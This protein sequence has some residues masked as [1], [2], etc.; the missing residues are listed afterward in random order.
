MSKH[1]TFYEISV[2]ARLL[3]D[4]G[5]QAAVQQR[6]EE[7]GVLAAQRLQALHHGL[8]VEHDLILTQPLHG[9]FTRSPTQER[10]LLGASSFSQSS[11]PADGSE[12]PVDR[13]LRG[14]DVAAANVSIKVTD[15]M[16]SS[17]QQQIN[18]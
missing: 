13:G 12:E 1:P 8:R 10:K 15:K 17:D 7:L 11:Q 14:G 2:H 6:V 16:E 5:R 18:K 4:G 9:F 3:L